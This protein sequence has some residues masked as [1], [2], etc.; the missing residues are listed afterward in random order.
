MF[1]CRILHGKPSE[2]TAN[3]VSVSSATR[4]QLPDIVV[5]NENAFQCMD[6]PLAATLDEAA[7]DGPVQADS[8]L[9]YTD[10]LDTV[11]QLG[12]PFPVAKSNFR[13]EGAP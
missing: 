8:V 13:A 10:P 7:A 2:R 4:C 3:S 1:T 11:I 9:P 12:R 6:G 5:L